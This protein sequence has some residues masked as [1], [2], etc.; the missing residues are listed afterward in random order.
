MRY[1]SGVVLLLMVSSVG[2]GATTLSYTGDDISSAA[3]TM[4]VTCTDTVLGD[5]WSLQLKRQTVNMVAQI[6]SFRDLQDG[7]TF[8]YADAATWGQSMFTMH[9]PAGGFAGGTIAATFTELH[10]STDYYSYKVTTVFTKGGAQKWTEETTYVVNPSTTSGTVFTAQAVLTNTSGGDIGS[11]DVVYAFRPRMG[12]GIGSY[13]AASGCSLSSYSSGV[14]LHKQSGGVNDAIWQITDNIDPTNDQRQAGMI[15][16]G[17]AEVLDNSVTSALGLTAGRTFSMVTDVLNNST[18]TSQFDVL[19]HVAP[20]LVYIAA[21]YN[22]GQPGTISDQAVYTKNAMLEINITAAEENL[23]PTADAGIDQSVTDTDDNDVETVTLDGSGSSDSDGTIVSWLWTEGV[24]QLATT[25]TADVSL[26]V[27]THTITLTVTDDDAA[28]HEDTVVITVNPFTPTLTADA[29]DDQTKTDLFNDGY[30]VIKFGGVASRPS[31]EITSWVWSEG[32]TQLATGPRPL[33]PLTV[34]THTITLTITD[35]D[36]DTAQDTTTVVVTPYDSDTC[37]PLTIPV[38]TTQNAPATPTVEQLPLV[39]SV[40]YCDVTWTFSSPARVGRFITGDYYVIGPVTVSSISPSWDGVKNGSMFNKVVN[41]WNSHLYSGLD[42]RVLF[43]RYD[44]SF[45]T[46]PPVSMVAGDILVSSVGLTR[47]AEPT[48]PFGELSNDDSPIES[49]SVLHCLSAPVAP[50]AFRPGYTVQPSATVYYSRNLNRALLPTVNYGSTVYP[51]IFT[52]KHGI[53]EGKTDITIDLWSRAFARPWTGEIVWFGYDAPVEYEPNYKHIAARMLSMASLALA[54]N[55]TAANKEK[56]LIGMVQ[57][58][59]D[60]WA[61]VRGGH[62]GWPGHGGHGSSR[63]FCIVLAGALLGDTNMASPK[64]TYPSCLFGED[65]QTCYGSDCWGDSWTGATVVFGGHQ[66]SIPQSWWLENIYGM[67]ATGSATHT[68]GFYEHIDPTEWNVDHYQS[69]SYRRCC[70]VNAW[71]G[72]DL[73]LLLM[74]LETQWNHDAFF[75]FCD[76]WMY[77][78]NAATA[79]LLE[80]AL[81][82]NPNSPFSP[83]FQVP[84][85]WKSPYNPRAADDF[86]N[87]MWDMFRTTVARP[88]DGW[89]P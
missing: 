70:N 82:Q 61:I 71:V 54:T 57:R 7:G 31:G 86:V 33:V 21:P 74:G 67:P 2:W 40:T 48:T 80:Q 65:E 16:W 38:Y 41:N 11:A 63:K 46:D 42:T 1:L 30:K 32:A 15:A 72:Y 84:I 69:E 43:G 3:G 79:A 18:S 49:T 26:A 13:T 45:R 55:E 52:W 4:T 58:G 66:Y 10:K 36:T 75:D 19:L 89:E 73:V 77:E 64:T 87:Q 9:P 81:Q 20:C 27:G 22:W 68:G 29:G 12:L 53:F 88:I 25:Q 59:I 60:L 24:T 62:V 76:R 6:I 56:L 17:Q 8:N 37:P 23:P 5:L 35:I 85:S 39:S 14:S 34:G 51:L 47:N 50:D 78:D 83:T 44:A 28:T